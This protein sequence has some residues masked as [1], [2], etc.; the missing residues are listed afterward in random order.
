MIRSQLTMHIGNA[1]II[2]MLL[3]INKE[4]LF[5][6]VLHPLAC[7]L[8]ITLIIDCNY[9]HKVQHGTTNDLVV[10]HRDCSS[11]LILCQTL[12]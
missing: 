10:G 3:L 8:A 4:E 2:R 1:F 5:V 7:L 12:R 11:Q 9:R 6:R